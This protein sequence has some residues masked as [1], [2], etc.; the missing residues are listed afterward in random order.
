MCPGTSLLWSGT[1]PN[2]GQTR[3]LFRFT[4]S[5]RAGSIVFR[6]TVSARAGS[7]VFWFTV[8]A[9]AG[10]IVFWFTVSA[11]AGSIVFWFTV[12]ARAGRIVFWFTVPTRAGRGVVLTQLQRHT[13]IFK[14]YMT[15]TST[16]IYCMYQ[17]LFTK[18]LD[19]HVR[20]G[21]E[22]NDCGVLSP[23]STNVISTLIC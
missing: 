11:R 14:H 1:A 19:T 8:S 20:P 6:F 4:V 10:S 21:C 23:S 12:S 18:D 17:M 22:A 3:T 5:A 2:P 15:N 16:V 13:V 7:I 9:R